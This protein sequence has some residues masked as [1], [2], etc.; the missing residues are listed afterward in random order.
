M[1]PR[2]VA[3]LIIV[4]VTTV[5]AF[6]F[7]GQFIPGLDYQPDVSINGIFMAIVGGALIASRKTLGRGDDQPPPAP[8]EEP[9]PGVPAPPEPPPPP[10]APPGITTPGRESVADLLERLAREARGGSR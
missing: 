2:S 8:P 5:W 7:V 3:N 6:N 10:S 4:L 1:I 9:P